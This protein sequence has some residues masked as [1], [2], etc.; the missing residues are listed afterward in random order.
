MKINHLSLLEGAREARGLTVVIDVFRAFSLECY[1]FDAGVEKIYAVGAQ[2]TARAL[3]AEHPEYVLAGE[4]G[5]I[6][7]PGFDYGNSPYQVRDAQLRGRTA[8]H[9]TSA[10]TQGLVNASHADEIIT[11]SLVNSRA[12]AEYIREKNPAEVSLVAMGLK[13]KRLAAEDELCARYIRSILEENELDMQA[14]LEK[15]RTDE[16]SQRFFDPGTQ[17]VFPQEDYWMCTD[18]DKFGFV[19]RVERTGEDVFEVTRHNI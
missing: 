12:I 9:T 17:D 14:E 15:L 19:L 8:V 6:M 11:G 18:V 3:K 2:E 1:L 13:G 4:R 5:G 10:G 16:T 7:L